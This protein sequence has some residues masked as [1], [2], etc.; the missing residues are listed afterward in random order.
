MTAT[1]FIVDDDASYLAATS[2]LLRASGFAVKPFSSA[3]AFLEER[4]A[5]ATGCVIA[6]LQMPDMNGLNLQAALARTLN[7]LPVIFLTGH[8]DI[9]SSVQ[10]IRG[11]AED[12]LE[13]R[14]PKQLLIEAVRRAIL[15]DESQ[16][17]ERVKNRDARNRFEKLTER[18]HEVLDHLLRGALNKQI[19]GELKISERTVKFHR[20]SIKTKVGVQSVA[21]LVQLALEAGIFP[22]GQ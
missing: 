16:R 7:A 9:R 8:G 12:F 20:T 22:K 2:R 21:E 13:K 10:A 11:G 18:E 6:D 19:A 1:V 15:R 4:D 3:R 17:V 14:A 5:N